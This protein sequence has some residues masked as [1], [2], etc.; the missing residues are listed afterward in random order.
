[1]VALMC[2]FSKMISYYSAAINKTLDMI[3]N[4]REWTS[5]DYIGAYLI[6]ILNTL[7]NQGKA[8]FY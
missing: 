4:H 5:F 3:I 7:T 2:L 8:H 1:M 6:Y